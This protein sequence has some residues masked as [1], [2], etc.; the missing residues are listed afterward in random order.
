V[1]VVDR[2]VLREGV[3]PSLAAWAS[4]GR[5]DLVVLA[6]RR[7][8]GGLRAPGIADGVADLDDVEVRLV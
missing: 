4:E 3:D 7:R 2:L 5:F 6:G 1:P 8:W